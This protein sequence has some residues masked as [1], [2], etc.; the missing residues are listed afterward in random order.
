MYNM[1]MASHKVSLLIICVLGLAEL[2]PA[3]LK[4]WT[5]A[6]SKD[7]LY[8]LQEMPYPLPAKPL[9]PI[10]QADLDRDGEAEQLSF[11]SSQAS[12]VSKDGTVWKS[13]DNWRVAQ[14]RLTDLDHDGQIE[15]TMLVWRPFKPWPIDAYLP[16][17]GR[18]QSFQNSQGFSCHLILVGFKGGKF[19]ELWA[20]SALS[21]PLHSFSAADVDGDGNE[22]LVALESDYSDPENAPARSLTFWEWNGFGFTLLKRIPG[23]FSD[24]QIE[25]TTGGSIQI[26]TQ[27]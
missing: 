20:G 17:G 22:E 2:S 14:A 24:F 27:R 18:I 16:H 7:P 10:L 26:V 5:F 3:R 1:F 25:I 15:L 12:L 9:P 13:P 8:T 4:S 11:E 21:E 19:R 23:S 6:D